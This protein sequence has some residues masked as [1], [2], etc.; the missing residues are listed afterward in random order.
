MATVTARSGSI[1]LRYS[2]E[3]LPEGFVL[4]G[5]KHPF[6]HTTFFMKGTWKVECFGEVY[7]R[8]GILQY[9][10]VQKALP[11]AID[12]ETGQPITKMRE[13]EQPLLAKIDEVTFLGGMPRAWYKIAADKHHKLTLMEGWGVYV[14]ANSERVPT[15]DVTPEHTGWG[16]AY[17]TAHN[18]LPDQYVLT[19]E[20]IRKA[21]GFEPD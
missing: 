4:D 5:H 20:R 14:C 6:Q 16:P 17:G 13:V 9:E 19:P 1:Y 12:T 3:L 15:G 10:K 7:N 21:L 8:N 18:L 2:D 11:V